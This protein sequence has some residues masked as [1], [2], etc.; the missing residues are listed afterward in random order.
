MSY[1]SIS[2]KEKNRDLI[3]QQTGDQHK[4]QKYV[5][6]GLK[7]DMSQFNSQAFKNTK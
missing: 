2:I 5:E 4:L 1:I 6:I 3:D 7:C